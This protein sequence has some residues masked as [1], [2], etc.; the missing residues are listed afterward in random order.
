MWN[1]SSTILVYEECPSTLQCAGGSEHV[2]CTSHVICATE[3]NGKCSNLLLWPDVAE[4]GHRL[5]GDDATGYQGFDNLG[6]ALLSMFVLMS[7]DGGMS[8]LPDALTNL[9]VVGNWPTW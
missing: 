7:A 1:A 9:A 2:Y 4:S 3:H 8:D 5:I 6:A